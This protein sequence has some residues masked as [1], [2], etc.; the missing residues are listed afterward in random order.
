MEN[1][2]L[3][4]NRIIFI[5]IFILSLILGN[6]F[7][8]MH[9]SSD[10]YVLLDLGYMEYPS[11]YFFNDGRLISTIICYIAGFLKI[12][13]DIYIVGMD[14]IAICLLSITIFIFYKK[15]VEIIG[16]E[17]ILQ[18]ILILLASFVLIFNQCT[19]EYLLF[20]ESA[21]MCLAL[22]CSVLAA[23]YTTKE[24]K[25]N[26]E[27]IFALLFISIISYQCLILAF[28][29]FVAFLQF[30]NF[31]NEKDKKISNIFKKLFFVAIIFIVVVALETL[32]IRFINT[33]LSRGSQIPNLSLGNLKLLFA[34]FGEAIK[35][36]FLLYLNFMNLLPK[37][38]LLIVTLISFIILYMDKKSRKYI[39][40]T[41]SIIC[42]I[43][44]VNA[45]FMTFFYRVAHGRSNWIIS[46]GWG[47]ALIY[48]LVNFDKNKKLGKV[49]AIFI[50][51]S[52]S[53]NSFMLLRNSTWHTIANTVDQSYGYIIKS[54]I[55]NYEKETGNR[56][57]KFAY[58]YDIDGNYF[59]SGIKEM[60]SLTESA[61]A[62]P[63]SIKESLSYY[64]GRKLKLDF[65][66]DEL[67]K[68]Q[69]ELDYDYFSDDLIVFIDDTMYILVY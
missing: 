1:Q 43:F 50:V 18:K 61:L 24:I 16:A 60:G 38:F 64:T 42:I 4:E 35:A 22:L 10:T 52:F 11:H 34:F 63:W 45:L 66:S 27:K 46:L 15:I 59:A 20:P 17:E 21:V 65:Y 47:I 62:C 19:L 32:I 54:K 26:W 41:I 31:K 8:R 30:L 48:M 49:I 40:Q 12:P 37:G 56:I 5:I 29:I 9:F 28:L 51:F 36:S 25:D 33:A 2:R 13:Y 6:Q 23:I 44:V 39:L 55:E 3:K 58:A 7:L 69:A 57:T 53:F 67:I 14:F 68:E